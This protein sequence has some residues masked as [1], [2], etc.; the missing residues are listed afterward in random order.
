MI[1]DEIVLE[2]FGVYKGRHA[3]A[4]APSTPKKPVILFGGLN[5]GG[6]TTLLDAFR[7]VFHGKLARCASRNG[8]GYTEFLRRSIHRDAGPSEG[9]SIELR[10]R[11]VAEGQEHS[12]RIRRSWRN[13]GTAAVKEFVE[14]LRDGEPDSV[15]TDAW[16]DHA[17]ELIPS[18]I[19]PL[20][21]FDGE[22]IEEFADLEDSGNLLSTAIHSLL[23]LDVVNRLMADLT[24]LE[25][26]KGSSVKSAP[27]RARVKQLVDEIRGLQEQR[28]ALTQ[29]QA[30]L[31]NELDK[32]AQTIEK[33][34][35][36]FRKEGGDLY[37]RRHELEKKHQD[38]VRAHREAEDRLREIAAG[39]APFLLVPDL[40]KRCHAQAQQE[41]EAEQQKAL[42][43]V[44]KKRDARLLDLA[45][46]NR[47]SKKLLGAMSEF[48]TRDNERRS[49]KSG[50]D[51]YLH[52]KSET[53][54]QLRG[55]IH[56]ELPRVSQET[57]EASEQAERLHRQREDFE[58][59]LAGVPRDE[60]I[61]PILR[62]RDETRRAIAELETQRHVLE[63][64]AAQI[65]Q[66]LDQ[67]KRQLSKLV[68]ARGRAA[69][70]H[71]DAGRI[72]IHARKAQETLLAFRE[73][74]VQNH[75][76]RLERF[77]LEGY[78]SLLRKQS[79][80]TEL[81]IDPETFAV[82]LYDRKH[83]LLP[84]DRL[85]AGE[86]QLFAVAMLWGLAR[87]SGRP[88]PTIIDTPLGRLDSTHRRH[89]IERYF[90]CASHQV[91]LLS[92][93]EEVDE[94][95]YAQLKPR[96]GRTYTLDYDEKDDATH[97]NPGYFWD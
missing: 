52:L 33:L 91:L 66:E 94:R 55:L 74:V 39:P 3:I 48:I 87:A 16:A 32:K 42:Q 17:E 47:A 67:A 85:S 60:A 70:E 37:E 36:R 83:N 81:R 13:N 95:Y 57:S 64:R 73:R 54:Q 21:F 93:D 45:R 18:S 76:G 19:C 9:A 75:V 38:C 41:H 59:A 34:E 12:Y 22:K 14:V 82:S 23:G 28:A 25:R 78:R 58:R 49:K 30:H 97:V 79:L 51:A 63:Q 56:S 96:V 88:L 1:F 40:L 86:R 92:T 72:A 6:K 29:E 62:E 71:K 20:F 15:L 24:V 68:E 5:G 8:L 4:L 35:E 61:E 10:F 7:L 80:V 11:T 31:Q 43:R 90:P 44:L 53:R 89:L 77:I 26:R 84:S 69:L 2:N 50:C 46:E 27:E 65:S